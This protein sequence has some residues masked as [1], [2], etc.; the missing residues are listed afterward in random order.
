MGVQPTQQ[1][2]NAAIAAISSTRLMPSD[3]CRRQSLPARIMRA[4]PHDRCRASTCGSAQTPMPP[5]LKKYVGCGTSVNRKDTTTRLQKCPECGEEVS[6][7]SP[8]CSKC[9]ARPAK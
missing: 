2:L 9:D 1:L 3:P 4:F 7:P 8:T 6:E 5:R